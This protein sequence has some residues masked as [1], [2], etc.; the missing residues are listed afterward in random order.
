MRI[1]GHA[2]HF[3]FNYEIS[4]SYMDEFHLLGNYTRIL[5]I[6]DCRPKSQCY[7]LDEEHH[8]L[9]KDRRTIFLNVLKQKCPSLRVLQLNFDDV[10][11]ARETLRT[12]LASISGIEELC[13]SF[14][15]GVADLYTVGN[16]F[17]SEQANSQVSGAGEEMPECNTLH[18]IRLRH[19]DISIPLKTHRGL[20]SEF[21]SLLRFK[22]L[23][24]FHLYDPFKFRGGDGFRQDTLNK[25]MRKLT[26][27]RDRAENDFIFESA[28]LREM[29]RTLDFH[30]PLP[31]HY[32]QFLTTAP[33]MTVNVVNR[34]ALASGRVITQVCTS[35][36]TMTVFTNDFPTLKFLL[37]LPPSL[38]HL[39][40]RIQVEVCCTD[41]RF[42]DERLCKFV[43]AKGA[44]ILRF[45]IGANRNGRTDDG[46]II[47]HLSQSDSSLFVSTRDACNARGYQF[48][49]ENMWKDYN[50]SVRSESS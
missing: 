5:V 33:H 16:I 12:L 14:H 45:G 11:S 35:L 47:R 10:V 23:S 32:S 30:D 21:S 24:K 28:W 44:K 13:L 29:D 25:F 1:L 9:H 50:K 2:L 15:L 36:R 7:P 19:F 27:S 4:K 48:I 49:L 6:S 37:R 18:T 43:E 39:T 3:N 31:E 20:P 38:D 34:Q 42:W 8:L 41:P 46:L 26:W 40:I 17:G 22:S